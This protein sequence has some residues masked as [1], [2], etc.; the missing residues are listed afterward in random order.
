MES[1]FVKRVVVVIALAMV[2]I[3]TRGQQVD[4]KIFFE[5][6]VGVAIPV[7]SFSSKAFN[8]VGVGVRING[9]AELGF[10][11]SGEFRYALSDIFD[12][13]LFLG[14]S[15]NSQNLTAL[16]SQLE[17]QYSISIT[18][19][20]AKN[21]NQ[22]QVLPG[23]SY[24]Q[25]FGSKNRSCFRVSTYLGFLDAKVPEYSFT[26]NSSR[27]TTNSTNLKI[28]LAYSLASSYNYSVRN[29]IS[30]FTRLSYTHGTPVNEYRFFPNPS[31][32]N[33]YMDVKDKYPLSNL[34][35]SIGTSIRLK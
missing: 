25:K 28:A 10:L 24:K 22:L 13:S 33:V 29:N 11:V 1:V 4:S 21:W 35:I 18:S 12:L 27:V 15:T 5:P 32:P 23:I 2:S 31:D 30:I 3:L 17:T 20:N 34:A 26:T 14:V 9:R 6:S 8:Q 7:G 16:K 19:V